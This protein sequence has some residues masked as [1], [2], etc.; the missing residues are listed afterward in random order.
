MRRIKIKMHSNVFIVFNIYTTQPF[1][2]QGPFGFNTNSF[3]LQTDFY[4]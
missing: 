2:S 4:F 3:N 1:F